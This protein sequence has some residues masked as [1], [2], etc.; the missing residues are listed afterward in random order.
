MNIN[1]K[2]CIILIVLGIFLLILI[3]TNDN[4]DDGDELLYLEDFLSEKEYQEILSLDTDKNKFKNENFRFIKP[5]KKDNITYEIFYSNKI[6]N[7]LKDKLNNNNIKSCDFPIEHRIYPVGSEGMQWHSDTLMYDKPQYE[8][9]YTIR[10]NSDSFT[11]WID[12]KDEYQ[13]LWTKP[14]SLLVVKAQ[15][16]KHHVT[17]PISGEREILKLIYT[18]SDKINKNYTDEMERFNK[19]Y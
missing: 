14:N 3:L 19:I 6:I 9:I 7:E 12:G 2:V 15:G 16:Y 13:K 17:P 8:A 1:K 11:G 5:L 10:N 4:N 18:Q